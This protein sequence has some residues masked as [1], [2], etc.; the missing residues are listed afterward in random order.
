MTCPNCGASV[1]ETRR[2]C[3]KCGTALTAT[4]SPA[5]LP[6]AAA[7]PI[8]PGTASG[9]ASGTTS[10]TG[11]GTGEPERLGPT[12]RQHRF[13]GDCRPRCRRPA[14][15]DPFAPPE[16]GSPPAPEPDDGYGGPPPQYPPPGYGRPPPA[17]SRPVPYRACPAPGPATDTPPAHQRARGHGLRARSRRLAP[18]RSWLGRRHHPRV[19]LPRPDQAVMG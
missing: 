19:R 12:G 1:A 11:P 9:T 4:A 7:P 8:A 2:F 3:G 15:P 18:V 13:S 14:S 6:T 10:G 16:L 5:D 17:V